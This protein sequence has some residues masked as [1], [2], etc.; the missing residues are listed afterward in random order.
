MPDLADV[1]EHVKHVSA[2]G[3]TLAALTESG[4]IYLWGMAPNPAESRKTCSPALSGVPNYVEIEDGK[5][6]E[7]MAVGDSHVLALTTDGSLY[8]FGDNGNG[9][10]GLG[11]SAMHGVQNWT[12]IDLH[13]PSG[14]QIVAVAAGPRS[15]LILTAP[16]PAPTEGA[17]DK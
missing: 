16:E 13:A 8:A 17:S 6:V 1:G 12:K 7:D 5:D 9:Q 3:Y 10:I 4:A 14:H 2:G 15:S 11:K